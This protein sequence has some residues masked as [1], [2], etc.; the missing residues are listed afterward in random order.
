MAAITGFGK[1]SILRSTALPKRMKTST[2]PP[3]KAEPRSAPAQK[4]RSPAPVMMTERT[5]SSSA[6]PVT[7]SLSSR[8]SVSLIALAGGRLSVMTA[9]LSS[10][11]T[12]R[13]SNAI[14][15]DSSQED[16]GDGVRGVG[17]PV[18]PLA[19]HPRRRH[20][21]HRTEQHLGRDLHGHVVAEDA[22]GLA[23]LEHGADEREVRRHLVRGRAAEEL[24]PLAELDLHHLRQRGVA[25]E[26]REV[27]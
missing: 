20:L 13:V 15:G 18:L 22:R 6:K 5:P 9:K 1:R 24:V 23:L 3:E 19:E 16:G 25:L 10:R 17:E 8:T 21:I 26:N 4:M 7:A 27:Q 12:S 14:D 11:L 2:L